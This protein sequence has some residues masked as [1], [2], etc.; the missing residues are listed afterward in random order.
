MSAPTI[1]ETREAIRAALSTVDGVSA[2]VTQPSSMLAA[3]DAWPVWV[4]DDWTTPCLWSSTYDVIVAL[5][6]ADVASAV[7]GIETFRLSI[8]DTLNDQIPTASV[9]RV[10]PAQVPLTDQ[11]GGVPALRFTVVIG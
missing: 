9:T 3:G 5:P 11:P 6:A 1:T 4:S 7:E 2:Y 8:V 10:E